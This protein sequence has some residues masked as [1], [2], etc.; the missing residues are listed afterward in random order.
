M[1][2]SQNM[3]YLFQHYITNE[4]T[5]SAIKDAYT[6]LKINRNTEVSWSYDD[7]AKRAG[8]LAILETRNAQGAAYMLADHAIA[9]GKKNIKR[10]VT[11]AYDTSDVSARP[12]FYV[13][14]GKD[15]S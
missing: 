13:E 9:M 3:K 5:A 15:A 7:Q 14:I 4:A 6:S 8:F 12:S 1:A 11:L 2:T 10:I